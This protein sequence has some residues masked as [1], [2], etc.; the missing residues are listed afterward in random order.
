MHAARAAETTE[1]KSKP[2]QLA[3][4]V[5]SAPE[6]ISEV[7]GCWSN[8]I[9]QGCSYALKRPEYILKLLAM[10][11]LGKAAPHLLRYFGVVPRLCGFQVFFRSSFF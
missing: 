3:R 6:A 9:I 1:R 8:D 7:S 10:L 5:F 2:Q 4:V 11:Q